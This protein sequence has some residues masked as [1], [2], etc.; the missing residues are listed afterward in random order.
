MNKT[1]VGFD[2]KRIAGNTTGLGSYGRTLLQSLA[3]N[4]KD[5]SFF[6]YTPTEGRK[7]LYSSLLSEKNITF[8]FPFNNSGNALLN[9]KIAKTLWREKYI[10]KDLLKDKVQVF[11]GLSGQLP[12]GIKK[13]G[14]KSIV[15]I[16]DLIFIPHPEWYSPADVWFYK[17]K[18]FR[19]VKQADRII[20]ISECTKRDIIRYGNVA[21]NKIEVI[22]QSF[23]PI[24]TQTVCTEDKREIRQKYS[25]PEKF[26]LN[27]GTIE[28]RKNV[29]L[30][31]KA[32]K[33]LTD[34]QKDLHLV[35]VGKRTEYAKEVESYI[36][37]NNLNNNVHIING[38][39]FEELKVIYSL[40]SIFVYPSVY[41][42]FGIPIIEAM[43]N[44][45]PVIACKGSCL[46]EAGGE[47]SLYVANNDVKAMTQALKTFLYNKER[48][49]QAIEEGLKHIKKFA[50]N[51]IAQKHIDLYN[52]L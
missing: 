43:S 48:K 19:T 14:V 34:S 26:I 42:G 17:Q 37:E 11:H 13:S 31:I 4:Y 45:L 35:I 6:L 24:F 20:A 50:N 49:E 7:E 47:Y 8:K 28:K 41:E 3:T 44:R 18:F 51:D 5:K 10:V 39:L 40:A 12:F 25:L 32:L 9:N 16:H 22:Y 36:Q 15:T 23:N 21:E 29:L 52:S 30:A 46:E 2:A 38:V 1:I 33:E 27:V